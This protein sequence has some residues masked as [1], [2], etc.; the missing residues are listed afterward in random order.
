MIRS[1]ASS[2]PAEACFMTFVDSD[3]SRSR[4]SGHIKLHGPEGFDG[5]RKAGRS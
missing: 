2:A 3:Q 1:G 5:M 4:R